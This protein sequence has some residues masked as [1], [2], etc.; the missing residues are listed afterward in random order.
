[1]SKNKQK[2]CKPQIQ[3]LS[4]KKHTLSGSVNKKENHGHPNGKR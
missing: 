3:K 4:V 2:W 1:M